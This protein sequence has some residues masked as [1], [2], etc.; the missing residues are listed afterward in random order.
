MSD[1]W[2][3]QIRPVGFVSIAHRPYRGLYVRFLR[4]HMA[5]KP[6]RHELFSERY[7]FRR[8]FRMAGLSLSF[9][10]VKD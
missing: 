10:R 1:H 9:K 8:T 7:G 5:L 4:W 6:T 2:Y 3:F